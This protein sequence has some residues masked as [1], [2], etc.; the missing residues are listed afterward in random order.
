MP[1]LLPRRLGAVAAMGT[2]IGIMVGSG[3]FRTP[4]TVAGYL[5][6]PGL[7]ML[8]WV[9]GGLL[10]LSGAMVFGELASLLPITGGRYIYLREGV[11]P[12]VAFVYAWSNIVLLRPVGHGAVALVLGAYLAPLVPGMAGR[13][14]E[15]AVIIIVALTLVNYRSVRLSA[16]ITTATSA[17]KVM[18]LAG[19]AILILATPAPA[20]TLITPNVGGAATASGFGLA[21][22]AVMWTYSGWGS[23]LY[24][25]GEVK[26]AERT[27]PLVLA[28]G[29]TFVMVLF[30]LVN[31]AFLHALPMAAIAASKAV[32]SDAAGSMYGDMGRRLAAIVVVVATLG[33]LNAV[34]LTGPRLPFAIGQ[35]IPLLARLGAVHRSFETPYIAVIFT[36]VMSIILLWLRSFE[37]LANTYILGAWPF[38]ILC[39]VALFRLRRLRPDAPRAFKVPGYPVVPIFFIGSAIAMLVNAAVADPKKAIIGSAILLSGVPV[40]YLLRAAQA[41]R[42]AELRDGR[43]RD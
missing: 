37:Q 36:A 4:A 35:D 28:G 38:Y 40:W 15:L 43:R 31:F 27:M 2:L 7:F 20:A 1:Q 25:T 6:T 17:I 5:P 41:G 32:A 11:S 39:G 23:S 29:V 22:V 18:A 16:A 12:L 14:R 33:S 19:I 3:I 13:D 30:V 42:D 8:V 9:A 34:S 10:A 26:R 21:L 24:I